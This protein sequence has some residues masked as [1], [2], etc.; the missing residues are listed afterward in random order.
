MRVAGILVVAVVVAVIVVGCGSSEN[1]DPV[2]T[3]RPVQ[4][5]HPERFPDIPLPPGYTL[6]QTHDQL[7]TTAAGGLVRRY[8]VFLKARPDGRALTGTELLDW[9][10]RQLVGLG[11]R[12]LGANAKSR[13]Y[14]KQVSDHIGEDLLVA[15][16][17][18]SVSFH[19]RPWDPAAP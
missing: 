10:D 19:L 16:A 18:D 17:G 6:D 2:T 9:Y 13:S 12:P 14:R 15:T 3:G 4:G 8:E 7:A 11:W 1:R 5:Y